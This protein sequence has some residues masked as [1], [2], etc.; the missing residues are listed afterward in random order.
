MSDIFVQSESSLETCRKKKIKRY[1]DFIN[2]GVP[3]SLEIFHVQTKIVKINF[4]D[5]PRDTKG[6]ISGQ[7][8]LF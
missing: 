2:G 7:E 8:I 6:S 3:V 5:S 1:R 4:K